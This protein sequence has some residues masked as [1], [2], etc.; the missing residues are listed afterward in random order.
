MGGESPFVPTAIFSMSAGVY[1]YKWLPGFGS[2]YALPTSLL[3]TS[4]RDTAFNPARTAAAMATQNSAVPAPDGLMAYAWSGNGYGTKYSNPAVATENVAS[5]CEFSASGAVV[6]VNIL[7]TSPYIAAYAWSDVSGFGTRYSSP[8]TLPEGALQNISASPAGGSVTYARTQV[9]GYKW[10]D[11]GGFGT[12][13]TNATFTVAPY[14]AYDLKFH[15]NASAVFTSLAPQPISGAKGAVAFS[16]SENAGFGTA[17]SSAVPAF[18]YTSVE[19]YFDGTQLVFA[20]VGSPY[21]EVY[22]FNAASGIHSKYTDPA[23]PPTALPGRPAFTQD[24]SAVMAGLNIYNFVPDIGFGS[25][26]AAPT[27]VVNLV[28]LGH[29]IWQNSA[30]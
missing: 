22:K 29:I 4:V 14:G 16:W 5:K 28:G 19:T 25:A 6:F 3:G 8:S 15:P 17:Y 18:D 20:K 26:I 10:T 1:A 24:G 7:N 12:K 9:G 2:L 23:S 21:V 30:I 27:A 13:Y 11:G